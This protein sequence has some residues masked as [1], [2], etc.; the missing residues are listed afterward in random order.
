MNE[1]G[2]SHSRLPIPDSPLSSQKAGGSRADGIR[3]FILCCE[4]AFMVSNLKMGNGEWL[5]ANGEELRKSDRTLCKGIT[6]Q[7]N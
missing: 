4:Q 2:I 1:S 5:I 6:T 3:I 7:Y